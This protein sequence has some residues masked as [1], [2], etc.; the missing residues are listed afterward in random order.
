[1]SRYVQ[2]TVV[3]LDYTILLGCFVKP[4]LILLVLLEFQFSLEF[5]LTLNYISY[6]MDIDSGIHSVCNSWV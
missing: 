3:A 6:C 2:R 4:F 5:S 1:M